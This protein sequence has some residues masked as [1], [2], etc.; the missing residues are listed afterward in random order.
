VHILDF[1]E[2]I[3]GLDLE[4]QFLFKIRDEIPFKT[5]A[6]LKAQIEKDKEV[7]LKRVLTAQHIE[8]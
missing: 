7:L 1:Q 8:E 2:S 5:V 3:Y 6:E 4:V